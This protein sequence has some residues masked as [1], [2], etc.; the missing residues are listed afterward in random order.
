[1]TD[2]KNPRNNK[3]KF[4][5]Q[6]RYRY[7]IFNFKKV[8]N[9]SIILLFIFLCKKKIYVQLKYFRLQFTIHLSNDL[10]REY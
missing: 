8:F 4:I 7:L 6:C 3:I 10:S 2:L 9:L 5:L 1:M